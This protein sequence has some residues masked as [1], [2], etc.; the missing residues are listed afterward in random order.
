MKKNDQINSATAFSPHPSPRAVSPSH[1]PFARNTPPLLPRHI[2][3]RPSHASLSQPL[4]PQISPPPLRPNH[5]LTR[6]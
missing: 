4:A 6:H 3:P 2:F 1:L 5:A